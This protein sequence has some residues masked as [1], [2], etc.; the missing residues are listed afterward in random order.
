[1]VGFPTIFTDC[2]T[3][4]EGYIDHTS[5]QGDPIKHHHKQARMQVH[6][7]KELLSSY[8]PHNMS[9]RIVS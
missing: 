1:M 3:N 5:D 8:F 6:K 2:N 7:N 4:L 9:I